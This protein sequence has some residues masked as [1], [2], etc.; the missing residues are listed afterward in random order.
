MSSRSRCLRALA[1]SASLAVAGV[2]ASSAPAQQVLVEDNFDTLLPEYRYAYDYAGGGLPQTDR[3]DL[4]TSSESLTP[5]GN[6]GSNAMTISAD[7]SGLATVPPFPDY[8]YQGF[9]GGFGHHFFDFGTNTPTGVPSGDLSEYTFFADLAA[10]GFNGFTAPVAVQLQF[11]VADDTFTPDADT[12]FDPFAQ[13]E[14]IVQ[15]GTD[16]TTFSGTLDQGTLT[17]NQD[18]VPA[19]NQDFAAAINDIAQLNV[20]FNVDAVSFGQDAD[21]QL[22]VEDFV[23]LVVPEPSSALLLGVGLV[24]LVGRRRPARV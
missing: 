23:V 22:I 5:N 19:G 7:F 15:A 21:N 8:N 9:G 11:Q 20:N 10:A 13:I 3:S 24:G 4:T 12:G 14:F 17:F 6:G 2:V 18:R 16:L 1:C